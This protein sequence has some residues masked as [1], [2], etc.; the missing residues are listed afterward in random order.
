M[1]VPHWPKS[2]SSDAAVSRHECAEMLAL[3][4]CEEREKLRKLD[5]L[6]Q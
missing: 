5:V 4:S 6:V 3:A 1:F 2:K